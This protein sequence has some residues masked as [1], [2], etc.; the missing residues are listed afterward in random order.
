[1]YVH[2]ERGVG[3]CVGSEWMGVRYMMFSGTDE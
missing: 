1:M 3:T 2:D